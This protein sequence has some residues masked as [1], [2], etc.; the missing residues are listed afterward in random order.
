MRNRTPRKSGVIGVTG[1]MSSLEALKYGAFREITQCAN[2]AYTT[3]NQAP[4]CNALADITPAP[5]LPVGLLWHGQASAGNG[6]VLR[7]RGVSIG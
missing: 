4:W 5:V 2:G 3:C 1:V 6:R 7:G